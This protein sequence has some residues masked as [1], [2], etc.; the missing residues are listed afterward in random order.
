MPFSAQLSTAVFRTSRAIGI[1]AGLL[2]CLLVATVALLAWHDHSAVR[3]RTEQELR[4]E[5]HRIVTHADRT[6]EAAELAMEMLAERFA[7][8]DWEKLRDAS[9]VGRA[10]RHTTRRLPQVGEIWLVDQNGYLQSLSAGATA[11]PEVDLFDRAY[12]R[13]HGIDRYGRAFL[14]RPLRDRLEGREMNVMS[15]PIYAGAH[16]FRGV[17]AASLTPRYYEPLIAPAVDCQGCGIALVRND[18]VVLVATAA[19]ATVEWVDG[20][21]PGS[22]DAPPSERFAAERQRFM[23]EGSPEGALSVSEASSRYPFR[24][25]SIAPDDLVTARWLH[26]TAPTFALGACALAL[27]L[28]GAW[29]LV[30]MAAEQERHAAAA[31]DAADSLAMAKA[32]AE[33]KQRTEAEARE[34]A[35][36]ANRAKSDFLAMMSHELR[37][38]LNAVLG[39]SEVIAKQAF[40]RAAVD[41]YSDYARHINESGQHL[42]SLINDILDLSKIEAGRLEMDP[43]PIDLPETIAAAIEL[44]GR[45]SGSGVVPVHAKVAPLV[46]VADHRAVTQIIVNLVGNALK[47]T[48]SGEIRVYADRRGDDLELEISDTGPGMDPDQV[49]RA[50]E[51]FCQVDMSLSRR[52]EGTGLGLPITER[53]IESMGGGM[54]IDS[55]PGSGTTVTVR[56]PVE[57]A[58]A[59]PVNASTSAGPADGA[60]GPAASLCKPALPSLPGE[61][62]NSPT[63]GALR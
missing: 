52:H 14:S 43:R 7:T 28:V 11:T 17:I 58:E 44:V 25:I 42:L 8:Q 12:W 32:E 16:S 34:E 45:K 24:V 5:T 53:L 39:F 38:P 30:R 51:P 54:T 40:G 33:E 22:P 31:R 41:R 59:T 4:S 46:V 57:V 1:A 15:L 47:F 19:V 20:Q 18:G 62:S 23:A 55:E 13:V 27:L 63:L 21:G 9:T 37:T 10:L 26:Q 6:L 50:L 2:A 61:P 36:N 48:E 29:V 3:E 56:L 49:R 35:A 60:G